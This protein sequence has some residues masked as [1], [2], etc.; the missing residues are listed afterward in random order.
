MCGGKWKGEGKRVDRGRER[1][2]ER[3]GGE[4]SGR[5]EEREGETEEWA[6]P[7]VQGTICTDA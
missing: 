7:M 4:R 2:R 1:V 3:E 5:E 6:F